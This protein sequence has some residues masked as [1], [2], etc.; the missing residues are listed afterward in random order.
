MENRSLVPLIGL[1]VEERFQSLTLAVCA[2]NK[3][4]KSVFFFPDLCAN[5]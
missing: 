3:K 4:A 2:V 1:T 5:S